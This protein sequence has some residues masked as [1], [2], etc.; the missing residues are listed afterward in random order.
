MEEFWVPETAAALETELSALL[1]AGE[2]TWRWPERW[3]IEASLGE[4]G[5]WFYLFPGFT[6]RVPAILAGVAWER[7]VGEKLWGELEDCYLN[8]TERLMQSP[9]PFPEDLLAAPEMPEPP[10]L[11]VV[12]LPGLAR[13]DQE[14][15]DELGDL[16]RSLA[17]AILRWGN[18]G[19]SAE[20]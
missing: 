13:L 14:G 5:G 7:E 12:M 11:A 18:P 10:W 8:F 16:E 19:D 1:R 3:R 6:A 15:L 17:L 20:E 9:A 2:H 4:G